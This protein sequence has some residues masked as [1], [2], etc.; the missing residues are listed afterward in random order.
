MFAVYS[1]LVVLIRRFFAIIFMV[2]TWPCVFIPTL[3]ARYGSLL[4]RFWVKKGDKPVWLMGLEKGNE[5]S[6]S[7]IDLG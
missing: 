5:Q 4:H 3:R 6:Q 7:S 1:P 2:F